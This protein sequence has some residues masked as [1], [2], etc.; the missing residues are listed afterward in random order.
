MKETYCLLLSSQ[1]ATNR[2][3]TT[4]NKLQFYVNWS[5]ILP[6][7]EDIRQ[8]YSL[9]FVLSG[10]SQGSFAE[11]YSVN[12]DLGG[13]N[14]YDQTGNRMTYL[15]LAYPNENHT[16]STAGTDTVYFYLQSRTHDN[17]PVTVEYPNNNIITVNITNLNIGSGVT[18]G[19]EYNLVLEFTPI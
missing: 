15:G 4:K 8:K 13:A 10:I 6:K 16:A 9:K 12:V 18:Y 14:I 19:G 2:I 3:G 1:N 7:P 11:I 17:L 5:A